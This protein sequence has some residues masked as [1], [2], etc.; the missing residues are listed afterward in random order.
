MPETKSIVVGVISVTFLQFVKTNRKYLIALAVIMVPLGGTWVYRERNAARAASVGRAEASGLA[1]GKAT[2]R[3]APRPSK[4]EIRDKASA[5][6]KQLLADHP[7]MEVEFRKV[8]DEDNGYLQW[9]NFMDECRANGKMERDSFILPDDLSKM[10][11]GELPWDADR[12]GKWLEENRGL[13]DRMVAL[14]LLPD[15]SAAGIDSRRI[16]DNPHVPT[17][18]APILLARAR[19]ALGAGDGATAVESLESIIGSVRHT[20]GIETPSYLAMVSAAGMRAK[21]LDF[22]SG[23]AMANADGETLRQLRALISGDQPEVGAFARYARG[24]WHIMS[25]NLLLPSL[26]GEWKLM[27]DVPP[28]FLEQ[29]ELV[30]AAYADVSRDL[31]QY[32]DKATLRELMEPMPFRN[33]NVPV[34]LSEKDQQH[35]ELLT[36]GLIQGLPK[37][38]A[39]QQVQRAMTDAALAISLGEEV[40]VEPV[41]GK[42]FVIDEAAGTLKLPDDPVFTGQNFPAQKIPAKR[43]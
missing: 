41:T 22:A 34:G 27:S 18:L 9:L 1:D 6:Q 40:P 23:D 17:N 35:F 14:G 29:P 2:D 5:W 12:F 37:G 8:A 20:E 16:L 42:P 10:M 7:E 11:E 38:W 24:D 33:V 13:V 25:E 15:R 19:L 3:G 4:K 30:A 31:A 36:H 39:L 21:M 28:S 32:W 43:N 26:L